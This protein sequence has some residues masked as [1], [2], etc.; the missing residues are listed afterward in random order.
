MGP[1]GVVGLNFVAVD[2]VMDYFEIDLDERCEFYE[3]VRLIVSEVLEI[4]HEAQAQ[5]MER[6]QRQAK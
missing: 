4:Q 3:S 2:R 1:G 6:L 5:E